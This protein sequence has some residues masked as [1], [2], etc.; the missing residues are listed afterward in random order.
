MKHEMPVMTEE[1]RQVLIA[2]NQAIVAQYES[3][4]IPTNGIMY[5]TA[6]IALA[7][8]EAEVHS[9]TFEEDPQPLYTV[10]PVPV[11]QPVELPE[12]Q[13]SDYGYYIFE[14]DDVVK[15]IRAAGGEVAE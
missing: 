3:C 8:L 7:S 14:A 13:W 1:T 12:K 6:K 9:Y 15:A 4:V 11:M 5:K 10:P 2:V